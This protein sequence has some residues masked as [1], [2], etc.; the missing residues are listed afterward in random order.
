M[1]KEIVLELSQ[2]GITY[3]TPDSFIK[4]P[5]VVEFL[6]LPEEKPMLES[7]LEKALIEHIEDFLLELGR[8]FM[9]VGSQL[10]N[11]NYKCVSENT[12]DYSKRHS[13]MFDF[14]LGEYLLSPVI[15]EACICGCSRP[16]LI[17]SIKL[18]VNDYVK[19]LPKD[20]FP[21][22]LWYSYPSTIIDRTTASRPY[23]EN[24]FP[25]YR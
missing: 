20:F 19:M 11:S 9:F 10:F 24:Y 6:C 5:M 3:N 4:D 14:K 1:N 23:I 22:N 17:H 12:A 7:D 21:Y 25:K 8:G 16:K 18:L 15:E 13:F 2:N